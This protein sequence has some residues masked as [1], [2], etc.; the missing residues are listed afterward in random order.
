MQLDSDI[1]YDTTRTIVSVNEV[2]YVIQ[3][4]LHEFTIEG[5]PDRAIC[6]FS[7]PEEYVGSATEASVE[8]T[9]YKTFKLQVSE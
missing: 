2:K 3:G 1:T 4:L 7:N 8:T 6:T 5:L 9:L